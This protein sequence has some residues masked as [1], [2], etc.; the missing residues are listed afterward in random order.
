MPADAA[1]G[2]E[3]CKQICSERLVTK[4]NRHGRSKQ[5]WE[6]TRPRNEGL[7]ARVYSMAAAW[8][9]GGGRFQ[10]RHWAALEARIQASE[11]LPAAAPAAQQAPRPA[12][13]ASAT[14]RRPF[15][16]RLG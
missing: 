5:E 13:S 4:R 3:H 14:A 10:E 1:Y 7:D 15:A 16:I 11:F 9:F 2:D 12:G 6:Q 8:D